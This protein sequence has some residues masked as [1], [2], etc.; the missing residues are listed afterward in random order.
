MVC[1]GDLVSDRWV[2]AEELGRVID[3]LGTCLEVFVVAICGLD[4]ILSWCGYVSIGLYICLP[5]YSSIC[6]SNQ[7]SSIYSSIHLSIHLFV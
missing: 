5:V 4:F 7:L 3:R 2:I 1:V 6:L